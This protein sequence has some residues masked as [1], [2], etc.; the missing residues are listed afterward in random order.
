M[1]LASITNMPET[2]K[3]AALLEI[4][5]SSGT[6]SVQGFAVETS[7]YKQCVVRKLSRLNVNTQ[8]VVFNK[9]GNFPWSTI[10]RDS[11]QLLI[12]KVRSFAVLDDAWDGECA[13]APTAKAI[14]EAED[15]IYLL[16]DRHIL[17]EIKQPIVSL[18]NDGEINFWWNLPEARFDIGFYGSGIYSYYAK[19]K[20]KEFGEDDKEFSNIEFDL[21]LLVILLMGFQCALSKMKR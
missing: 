5:W 14:Q 15:F 6:S 9:P 11:G 18:M 19:I 20:D 7:D 10:L 13:K 4:A 8:Q 12:E 1:N 16:K 3:P 21:Q 17:D 2:M